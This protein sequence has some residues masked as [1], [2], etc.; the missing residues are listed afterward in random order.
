[1]AMLAH[2]AAFVLLYIFGC[3]ALMYANTVWWG[4]GDIKFGEG[5]WELYWP[6]WSVFYAPIAIV[7][8]VVAWLTRL[9]TYKQA[10]LLWL[11]FLM[12]LT[13]LEISFCLDIAAPVLIAEWVGLSVAFATVARLVKSAETSAPSDD[14]LG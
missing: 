7:A 12:T 6:L 1:M 10:T 13:A 8:I 2:T 4:L 9:P 11:F 5:G 14:D 3:G